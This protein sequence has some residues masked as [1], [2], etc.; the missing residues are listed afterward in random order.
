MLL[1]LIQN[2]LLIDLLKSCKKHFHNLHY[3]VMVLEARP[4]RWEPGAKC[5]RGDDIRMEGQLEGEVGKSRSAN[6][7][8]DHNLDII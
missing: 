1:I 7:K 4:R 6:Y 2:V 8:P 5:R 3:V